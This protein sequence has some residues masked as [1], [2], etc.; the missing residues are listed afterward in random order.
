M[1]MKLFDISQTLDERTPVWP[2][3]PE[4]SKTWI[5]RLQDGAPSNVSAFHFGSHAGTHI[6]APLHINDSGIDA[7]S[8]PLNKLIGPARVIEIFGEECIRASHLVALDWQGVERVLF[9]TRSAEFVEGCE[10]FEE[11]FVYFQEGAAEFLAEKSIQLIGIDS[12]SIDAF[13]AAGLPSHRIF[14]DKG[15]VI[16]EGIRL[17]GVAPGEYTLICLPLK[18]PGA[19]G[20]P[21]RAVLYRD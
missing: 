8:I 18:I 14:I 15:I 17:N 16:L 1:L 7:A 12:P 2:G 19:D 3:D 21:G 13:A 4:F 6:D 9:K 11:N 10:K 5:A 20:S